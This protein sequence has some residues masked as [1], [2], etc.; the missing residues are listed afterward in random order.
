MHEVAVKEVVAVLG[1]E[2]VMEEQPKVTR[3]VLE[4]EDVF[5]PCASIASKVVPGLL[6]QLQNPMSLNQEFTSRLEVKLKQV[7]MKE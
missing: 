3:K 2:E 1:E 7:W 6:G 4:R 5:P